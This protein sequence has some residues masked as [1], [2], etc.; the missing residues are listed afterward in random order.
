MYVDKSYKPNM[1]YNPNRQADQMLQA[2]RSGK[3][4]IA[5][6][7]STSGTS[8]QS[9][10]RLVDVA[11][12]S[13][14]ELK[15]DY[16]DFLRTRH[17]SIWGKDD[18]RALE[19][20]QLGYMT[21]RTYKTYMTYM[22]QAESAANCLL[23]LINQACYLLDQQ[24][25]ALDKDLKAKGDFKDRLKDYRKKEILGGNEDYEDFLKSQG[26]RRLENGKVVG[27]NVPDV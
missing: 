11:R 13:P 22:V 4:N 7:S 15:N 6:S 1:S 8:K 18:P 10:L 14:E 23:C 5:E 2:A 3:Q 16:E 25:R 21:D 12:A 19:I 20:R 27:L 26:L 17:L 9:E 24:L